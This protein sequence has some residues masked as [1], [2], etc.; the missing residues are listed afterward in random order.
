MY[1]HSPEGLETASTSLGYLLTANILGVHFRVFPGEREGEKASLTSKIEKKKKLN[2]KEW[3]RTPSGSKESWRVNFCLRGKLG[4]KEI[5]HE[6][7]G[8]KSI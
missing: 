8:N 2:T 4:G 1:L 5:I 6:E 7:S 3:K